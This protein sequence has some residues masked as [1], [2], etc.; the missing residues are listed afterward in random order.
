MP[1]DTVS[2]VRAIR[3]TLPKKPKSMYRSTLDWSYYIKL[4]R[5]Q[6]ADLLSGEITVADFKAKKLPTQTL[7]LYDLYN[8]IGHESS[9]SDFELKFFSTRGDYAITKGSIILSEGETK[10]EEIEAFKQKLPGYLARK[11]ENGKIPKFSIYRR[12]L[13]PDKGKSFIGTKIGS[14]L[15]ELKQFDNV[16]EAREYLKD[17]TDELIEILSKYK[18]LPDVREEA[19]RERQGKNLS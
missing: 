1:K 12:T 19:N 8:A 15:V 5:A 6:T 11:S 14:N 7:G 17:N 2:L 9:L 3:E 18:E 13:G 4:L 10:E 16:K